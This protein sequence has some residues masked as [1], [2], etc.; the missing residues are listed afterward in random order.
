MKIFIKSLKKVLC[1]FQ[2]VNDSRL[3]PSTQVRKRR[4]YSG[5]NQSILMGKSFGWDNIQILEERKY[6]GKNAGNNFKMWALTFIV[7][8]RTPSLHLPS[9]DQK[10]CNGNTT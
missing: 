8:H 9:D 10:F 2:S 4:D 6:D 7:D 5:A 3:R 1:F